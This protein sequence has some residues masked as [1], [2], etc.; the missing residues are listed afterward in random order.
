MKLS[1]LFSA[2]LLG[3]SLTTQAQVNAADSVMSH[4]GGN[5]FSVGGYGEVALSRMFYSNNVYRYMD[6]GKYKKDPSHGE[7]SLPHVVVYL[8]YDFGKGW[9][10]GSEIEF[11]HGGTGS[12]YEREYEE[13]G[14]W[15]SE[16]EKG[17]EVELEQ[18]WLQKSFWQGKLNVRVGH[19]VVPVGL[20]NA[21][22]EPLNFFTVYRP[23]GENTII[24]STWHQ[25]GISLWGRLPQWRYEVQFL[26]GLDALEFNRE[27][28]IHDGTKDPFEFEPA[29]KYGVSARIDNY[30]LPGLRIGLSSYYG[31]SIDNTYV[32]NADGQESKLKGAIA[33]GS[34][35]FTLDRWNWIVRGQ[36]DYGHL[37]D[38]YDIVNLG[39]RQSR[40]SPYSHDLVGKNAVAVGIEAGYDLF[41]Q[42]QKLRADNQKLYIFGR[43]EYYNPYVRDK[44]Q[45]AYEYT[46]KQ[47]L[48]VGVNY[49]PLPQIVVKADYSHRFLKSPYDN[50]PSIN[51][52]VAYQGFFL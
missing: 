35:D 34:V 30:S 48:A 12:A 14:E 23:E 40:T 17:G 13:G 51:L 8:G 22:H 2:A 18:F 20:N 49:Y 5:R 44:R 4:A 52:G 9:T 7:F 46:K 6:P 31:H 26:A 36:A 32:R 37:S 47:R 50:E 41:S 38:A 21:H 27:G 16:V 15:E 42:I 43:Y 33:F 3:C 19:I 39:G 29:N 24:P 25:T 10:M 11:E 45:V 28:W 1:I